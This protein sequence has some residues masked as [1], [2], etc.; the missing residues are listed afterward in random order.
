[1]N[2]IYDLIIIGSGPAGLAAS[3]YASR[4][5]LDHLIFGSVPGGQMD[6]IKKI[7]NWPG[8]ISISGAE[9]IS[10]FV[11]QVENYGVKIT[12]ES[13]SS[14]TKT[15]DGSFELSTG[16]NTYSA[17]SVLLAMGAEYRR[18]N[19]PGEKALTGKGVSYCATC[20]GFFFREKIVAVIGGGNS[21]AVAALEL[22]EIAKKVYIIFRKEK[23][24]AEP[25][26]LDK[27]AANDKI[28][29]VPE[30]NILEIK[31]E[32]KVERV[33]IDKP[34]KDMTYIELDGVF[35]EIG[36]DPGIGLA[37]KMGVDIDEQNYI[38][39]NGDQS[40]NITGLYA[41]GD[42]TTA[43]N[44]FRQVLTAASEGSIAAAS[45]YKFVKLK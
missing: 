19:I 35:V 26:W 22:A 18:I 44:K 11:S 33:V 12:P 9:L 40:T 43:S 20:D 25:F 4:Y 10:K 15:E 38:K 16:K 36:S 28:E 34:L 24:A 42:I 3:L 45:A 2:K 8:E 1:M 27:M 30:T 5:K 39:V 21:A 6:E 32:Q 41:A 37:R 23:M 17:K 14:I 31:G 29:L 13:V 7:E